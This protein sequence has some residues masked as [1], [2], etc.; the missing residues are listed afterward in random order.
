MQRTASSVDSPLPSRRV[1]AFSTP[2]QRRPKYI[3]ASPAIM[4]TAPKKASP[5]IATKAR[6]KASPTIV[7]KAS[8]KA[9]K[10]TKATTP[11]KANKAIKKAMKAKQSFRCRSAVVLCLSALR[12]VN[13]ET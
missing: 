12:N 1:D 11:T 8:K 5:T 3:T 2:K 7:T 10:A 6:K 9:M 13:V 4:T